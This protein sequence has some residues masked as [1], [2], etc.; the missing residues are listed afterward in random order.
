MSTYISKFG[1]VLVK[2]N[3]TMKEI[4]SI[5]K[6]LTARPITDKQL[7]VVD[8]PV[9]RETVTKLYIPKMYGIQKFGLPLKIFSNYYGNEILELE[10]K[11]ALY[12][13]QMEP[14]NNI[15]QTLLEKSGAILNVATGAGKTTIALHIVTLLLRKTLVIV[16]KITLM[17]QWKDEIKKFIPLAKIGTIQGQN[18]D[19]DDKDIVVG[20]LQSLSKPNYPTD[21]FSSF[22]M[23]IFDECHNLSSRMFSQTMFKTCSAFTL[24]LSAT[25]QRSDSCEYVFKWHIGDLIECSVT[26]ER[27]G[28]KPIVRQIRLDSQHYREIS[29]YNN[30]TRRN[31]IQF[32]SMLTHLVD[33]KNRNVYIVKLIE[34]LVKEGRKVLVMSDRRNH[35]VTIEEELYKKKVEFTH[36]LFM[37]SMKVHLLEETKKCNVILATFSA[38]AEG[39]SVTDLDTLVLITPK[40]YVDNEKV[41]ANKKKDNGKMKQIVGRI[42]RKDHINTT[43]LIVDLFDN[44]SVYKSQAATRRKFYKNTFGGDYTFEKLTVNL[45]L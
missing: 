43:P 31:Q 33:M 12:P 8:F 4:D 20:M 6:D 17:N 16:N 27:K 34:E 32:T 26:Q 40:K 37:G 38:F 5:K 25:P 28:N 29:T 14:A 39:V 3:F 9:Y 10:F 19:I 22:G 2:S 42:F 35:L 45:D 30:F 13:R 1:Y 11:G 23:I 36:G 15:H 7:V 18:V 24:G 44:F 21:T 41:E